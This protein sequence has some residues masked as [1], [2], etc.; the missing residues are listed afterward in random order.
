[1]STF[2]THVSG[3]IATY[4]F[5]TDPVAWYARYSNDGALDPF[6]TELGGKRVVV[7]GNYETYTELQKHVVLDV[8]EPEIPRAVFGDESILWS[9][10]PAHAQDRRELGAVIHGSLHTMRAELWR[11][12]AQIDTRLARGSHDLIEIVQDMLAGAVVRTVVG[13]DAGMATATTIARAVTDYIRRLKPAFAFVPE[14]RRAVFG[15]RKFEHAYHELRRV[16]REALPESVL[17][18]GGAEYWVDNFIALFFAA[19]DTTSIVLAGA[20]AHGLENGLEPT[21]SLWRSY[22][23]MYPPVPFVPRSVTHV[24]S[25]PNGDPVYRFPSN[26]AIYLEPG[27]GVGFM[28]SHMLGDPRVP[29]GTVFGFS[30]RKCLGAALATDM[31]DYAVPALG[32]VL[33]N[34]GAELVAPVTYGRRGFN[35]GPKEVKIAV[36]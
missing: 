26:P 16:I 11:G 32:W 34:H 33:Y 22:V 15:W 12:I 2:F 21:E 17:V 8:F 3:P 5:L 19:V 10:T 25:S 20:L 23:R 31:L 30:G 27:N 7:T 29:I 18:R 28:V 36:R 24:A 9:S 14:S 1:M 35:Y 4:R 13:E 6:V